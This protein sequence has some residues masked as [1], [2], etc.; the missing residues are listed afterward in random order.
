MSIE[1]LQSRVAALIPE[2]WEERE[3]LNALFE[4]FRAQPLAVIVPPLE[5]EEINARGN[6]GFRFSIG[7]EY[8]IESLTNGKFSCAQCLG[9]EIGIFDTEAEAMTACQNHKRD[10][11]QAQVAKALEGC[12][13]V[14]YRDPQPLLD[15]LNEIKTIGREAECDSDFK[16]MALAQAEST[17]KAWEAG[18]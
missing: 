11:K 18:Q 9:F 7:T 5:W 15:G 13:V 4:Q 10:R 17:L 6:R 12:N 16:D 8:Y 2:Y 1:E 3:Q 14:P